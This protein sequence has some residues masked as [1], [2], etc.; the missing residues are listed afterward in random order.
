MHLISCAC[1]C[2]A[3]FP[4]TRAK[5]H[6]ELYSPLPITR[7]V[8]DEITVL[9]VRKPSFI[10]QTASR[11]HRAG[12]R[13]LTVEF[14]RAFGRLFTAL[15]SLRRLLDTQSPSIISHLHHRAATHIPT[16]RGRQPACYQ[17]RRLREA[18]KE[19][20][21]LVTP[22]LGNF[23]CASSLFALHRGDIFP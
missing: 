11:L 23:P 17:G 13:W 5:G 16:Q 15:P 19:T 1:P 2:P 7:W 18:T 3:L 8:C 10:Y 4:G 14:P 22:F 21:K 9:V 12:I 20:I 6:P